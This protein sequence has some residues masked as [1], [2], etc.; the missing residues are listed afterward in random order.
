VTTGVISRITYNRIQADAAANPGNSGGPAVDKDGHVVGILLAGGGE[1]VNFAV[2][3]D[4][5]CVSI[6]RC[7]G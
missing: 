6:R 2:P 1:N 4:R 7:A 3:I 5:A